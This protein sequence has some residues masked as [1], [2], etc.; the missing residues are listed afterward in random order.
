[1]KAGCVAGYAPPSRADEES[2]LAYLEQRLKDDGSGK[3][4]LSGEWYL[5]ALSMTGLAAANLA[6][7]YP[8]TRDQRL[9][10]VE[11]LADRALDKEVRAFDVHLWKSDPLATLDTSEG[12]AGYLGHLGIL[13]ATE[14]A[15]GGHKHEALRHQVLG[16]LERRYLDSESGMIETYPRMTWIPDNAAALAG[17]A[18][19]ARCDG[20]EPPKVVGR[21]PKDPMTG[22]YR[23][24]PS[25]GARG[26]GAGW[27]S[28]YL[29]FIDQ[30]VATQQFELAQKIFGWSAVGLAAW[31]EYPP[32][33]DGPSDV[34]SGPVIFGLGPSATGFAIAGA[35]RSDPELAEKMARTAETAGFTVPWGGGRHY[36]IAPLVGE[37]I[38]LATRTTV[39]WPDQGARFSTTTL[40]GPTE[41]SPTFG[42]PSRLPGAAVTELAVKPS[43][44]YCLERPLNATFH[45]PESGS[46]SL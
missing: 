2:R 10:Q 1:V 17:V 13:L 30:K 41:T 38:V 8:E 26:S 3:G 21:W 29:P 23:F 22:L 27:N 14:C 31:R 4:V 25:T 40:Y 32:G 7:A 24:T 11:R 5:G 15:L 46:P 16:A 37:A 20:R 12:H 9:A 44:P 6:F 28:I 19:S 43:N 39:K 36:L 34:D 42:W 33:I 18:I 45:C 35:S